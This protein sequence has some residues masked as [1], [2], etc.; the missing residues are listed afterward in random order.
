MTKLLQFI[1]KTLSVRLSLAVTFFTAL[2][3]VAALAVVC[4][5]ARKAVKEEA[6][7][8]G[9]QRMESVVHHTDI[10][11]YR[12]ELATANMAWNV[13]HHL[14]DTTLMNTYT[15]Q[16]LVSNPGIAGCAIA[17]DP[18]T[19]MAGGSVNAYYSF[20]PDS[21]AAIVSP[22]IHVLTTMFGQQPYYEQEWYV[23]TKATNEPHWFYPINGGNADSE[24]MASYC[25][26]L[27]NGKGNVVGV[28]GVDIPLSWLTQAVLEARPS[29][30][31]SCMMLA[32]D[33]TYIVHPDS[34]RLCRKKVF[35]EVDPIVLQ[36]AKLMFSGKTDY[37]RYRLDDA[38]CY[39]FYKPFKNLGWTAAVI[40]PEDDISGD[41]DRLLYY[42]VAIAAA[43]L[44][45]MLTL[46]LLFTRRQLAPLAM[47]TQSAQRIADGYFD[48]HIP[49]SHQ[50]DEIGT[51]QGNFQKMQQS[52]AA[53]V[54]ELHRLGLELR[55]RNDQLRNA[56]HMA[57]EADRVKTMF[58]HNMTDQMLVPIQIINVNVKKLHM[59]HQ[60]MTKRQIEVLVDD[61][62]QQGLT[63][64]AILNDLLEASQK[65]K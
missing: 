53:H 26:P 23:K 42:M 60:T 19:M 61:I 27:H 48:E 22:A 46:C 14:G 58:L 18:D 10:T 51:L 20:R 34:N 65:A 13:E 33:G 44:L 39:V 24:S 31:S 25:M 2:I 36:T 4:I 1:R 7:S 37:K 49:D 64:A 54:S 52:L 29:P 28:I 12:M 35:D 41:Y 6:L 47:L 30:N 59:E 32:A 56:N 3:L 45:L 16:M 11:L 63:I 43:G 40:Y 50:K 55:Q 17:F 9:A 38:D 8:K 15:R 57:Q 21:N 5:Y 62:Q